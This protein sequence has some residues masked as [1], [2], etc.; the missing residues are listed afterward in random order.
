MYF[1]ARQIRAEIA[2]LAGLIVAFDPAITAFSLMVMTESLFL[3]IITCFTFVFMRY[4]R[5][6]SVRLLADSA[7][8]LVAAVY[9]RPV[10][11]FLG[12]PVALFIFYFWGRKWRRA[13]GHALVFSVVVCG[14]LGLWHYRNHAHNRRNCFSE[15]SSTVDNVGLYKSYGRNKDESTKGW[16]PVAY[17]VNVTARSVVALFTRPES[18]KYWGLRPLTVGGKIFSYPWIAFWFSGF[19]VGLARMNTDKRFHF[20]LWVIGYFTVTTVAATMWNASPRFRVPMM[21]FIAVISAA[22]LDMLYRWIKVRRSV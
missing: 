3:F 16:P 13:L 18:F 6:A 20:L 19:I 4:L 11:Y 17:Y 21:P 7:V 12:V 15:I 8:L 14:L 2:F 9:V 1:I 10:A 22:G 5:T